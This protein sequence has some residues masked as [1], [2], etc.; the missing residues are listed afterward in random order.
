MERYIKKTK[1]PIQFKPTYGA[2]KDVV[3]NNSTSYPYAVDSYYE[4]NNQVIKKYISNFVS[5]E[6]VVNYLTTDHHTNEI[7]HNEI[8]KLYIDVDHINYTKEQVIDCVKTINS[9]LETYLNIQVSMDKIVILTN[10]PINDKYVSIHII[11][12]E[13]CMDYKQQKQLICHINELENM[14]M[15]DCVYHN[16]QLFRCV[17]QTKMEKKEGRGLKLQFFTHHNN[18]KPNI[19]DSI[20][21]QTQDIKLYKFALP[22]E[23]TNYHVVSKTPKEIFEIIL[24]KKFE[25]VFMNNSGGIWCHLTKLNHQFNIF[26]M[27]DWLK[28]SYQLS[29]GKYSYEQN[30]SFVENIDKKNYNY[31]NDNYL[32][33]IMNKRLKNDMFYVRDENPQEELICYLDKFFTKDKVKYIVSKINN[34]DKEQNGKK[35]EIITDY[36]FSCNDKD[37]N[38]DIAKCFITTD[39]FAIN[40]YYDTIKPIEYKNIIHIDNINEAKDKLN[41]FMEDNSKLYVLKSSWG[42]GKTHHILKTL[43]SRY[44]D[45]SILIITSVNSL[46]MVNTSELNKHLKIIGSTD[47]FTSH[48]ETQKK[49]DE[50]IILSKCNKVICSIQSLT[51]VK[52]VQFTAVIMDEFESIMNGYFGYTTFKTSVESTFNI[53]KNILQRSDKIVAMDADISEPKINLLMDML[54]ENVEC[55][56]YKNNTLSFRGVKFNIFYDNDFIDLVYYILQDVMKDYK[57]VIPCGTRSKA[58]QILYMLGN[59]MTENNKMDKKYYDL[60]QKYYETIKS[61]II[62]YI[63]RDGC[64]LYKTNGTFHTGTKLKNEDVYSSIDNF[65]L[66]NKVDIFIYT[67]TITTGISINKLYFH[68]CYSISSNNSVN[69]L[70][71]LQM[72][73]RTRQFI[74]NEVYIWV[75]RHLFSKHKQTKIEDVMNS[76]RTR[77]TLLN[78][79]MAHDNEELKVNN[80]ITNEILS[81]IEEMKNNCIDKL[82]TDYYCKAQLINMTNICNTKKNF[83]YNLMTT[84]IYHGLDYNYIS[85]QSELQVNEKESE[86]CI[87]IDANDVL[88]DDIDYTKWSKIPIMTFKDYFLELFREEQTKSSNQIPK[89]SGLP[90]LEIYF[91]PPTEDDDTLESYKKTKTLYKLLKIDCLQ[92]D[93]ITKA[94]ENIN[95][96]YTLETLQIYHDTTNIYF[97]YEDGEIGSSLIESCDI[98]I[99]SFIKKYNLYLIWDTYIKT[100]KFYD[101]LKIRNFVKNDIQFNLSNMNFTDFD[102]NRLDR[103]VLK[104]ICETFDIDLFNPTTIE[105]TNEELSQKF[106]Q[107]KIKLETIYQYIKDTAPEIWVKEDKD[108]K[109]A[110]T[111]FM[112]EHL[113]YIDYKMKYHDRKHTTQPTS[114][115]DIAPSKYLAK[116]YI[117]DYEREKSNED[118][119][120]PHLQYKQRITF[121]DLYKETPLLEYDEYC[122]IK[123]KIEKTNE[124]KLSKKL[125]QSMNYTMLMCED[126]DGSLVYRF[127]NKDNTIDRVFTQYYYN[128]L[129]YRLYVPSD[130]TTIITFLDSSRNKKVETY[131]LHHREIITYSPNHNEN[132]EITGYIRNEEPTIITR[133]YPINDKK[134]EII[135]N[136]ITHYSPIDDPIKELAHD[137]VYNIIDLVFVKLDIHSGINKTLLDKVKL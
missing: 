132:N 104:F 97:I 40:Y 64:M 99:Q 57:L 110:M 92:N 6:Q 27:E 63:D 42:T 3:L 76:N 30:A 74:M 116:D 112:K 31:E 49:N 62:L 51:K 86:M 1:R 20:V 68:K 11:Y 125:K 41:I 133:P 120:F 24:E 117:I 46:N 14:N 59:T 85:S 134:K 28:Q 106:K 33:Y 60:V 25:N 78:E 17:N 114:K 73:M 10:D 84:I 70:E 115:L 13:I 8:R 21:S 94:Y 129:Y 12:N 16:N 4:T 136:K 5:L 109:K 36:K 55:N 56:V 107:L 82:T 22:K 54:G 67:P 69:Y 101:V 2:Y 38:L 29:D 48:L 23:K 89:L 83:V 35:E 26:P 58:K 98:M 100:S 39:D 50:N 95:A 87:D 124:P 91:E 105:L 127:F 130:E 32:Y 43:L 128:E 93:I 77:I 90:Q 66:E 118:Y 119:R 122:K 7:L 126:I 113:K 19:E 137:F 123:K 80:L 45:C 131:H 88:M 135:H 65:L 34:P 79:F 111:K 72:I 81:S 103:K 52:D 61:K 108:F 75:Q 15:D 44:R 37:Y 18:I 47:L 9:Q 121:E 102:K 96:Q 53:L 71:Y